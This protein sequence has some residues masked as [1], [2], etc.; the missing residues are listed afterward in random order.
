[1]DGIERIDPV[2]LEELRRAMTEAAGRPRARRARL[3]PAL[4]GDRLAPGAP[5]ARHPRVRDQRV[6]SR[7]RRA[8][9]VIEEHDETGGGAGGHEEVYIVVSRPRDLHAR[10]RDA[11]CAG[12]DDRLPLRPGGEAQ[13]DRRGGGDARA[14][15]RR[16]AGR[17]VRGLGVGVVLRRDARVPRGALG[18]G[19]R[20]DASRGSRRS[21]ATR[22]PLQPRVRGVPG[23]THGRRA[24]ASPGAV[25]PTRS[26]PTARAT[27][28]TSTRSA[29]SPAF[30][31]RATGAR[32]APRPARSR[33]PGGKP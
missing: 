2:V 33:L 30:P 3:D 12:R 7:G 17:A 20:A 14:R 22:A 16:R 23:G 32:I 5:P 1:M 18:R 27:T 28:P 13:G 29:A 9:Q 31:L 8:A 11:R 25:R 24:R 21:P 4:R 15:G 19:D 26:T 6:H 10:R